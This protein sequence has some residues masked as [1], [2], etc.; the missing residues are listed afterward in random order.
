M[1]WVE[2]EERKNY[3]M[4]T[5]ALKPLLFGKIRFIDKKYSERCNNQY[6]SQA[7]EFYGCFC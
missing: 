2:L 4:I 6:T 1:R 5:R 7:F 3:K